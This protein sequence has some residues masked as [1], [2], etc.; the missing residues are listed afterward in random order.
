MR[1]G[2]GT[3]QWWIGV[4]LAACDAD[5]QPSETAGDST[6]GAA[7]GE[8]AALVCDGPVG[9]GACA[10]QSICETHECG[11]KASLY[12]HDGCPRTQCSRDDECGAGWRCYPLVLAGACV[13]GELDCDGSGSICA[14]EPGGECTGNTRGHCLP[15]A[16]YPPEQDCQPLLIG[17]GDEL[18][19]WHAAIIAARDAHG[20]DG[21]DEL[22]AEL[23]ACAPRAIAAVVDCGRSP[24]EAACGVALC[25]H[26]DLAT[27]VAACEA[28]TLEVP[29]ADIESWLDAIATRPAAACDCSACAGLDPALC[30]ESF[31][32]AG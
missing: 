9:D 27:C 14:C 4:L 32:C 20:A 17:C 24:C 5:P 30:S 1:G 16:V 13:E 19:A 8:S 22:A 31:G 23:S 3:R 25:A 29:A 7:T 21:R 26:P 11:G 6:D 18:A 28:A 10:A 2:V 15:D 12:N